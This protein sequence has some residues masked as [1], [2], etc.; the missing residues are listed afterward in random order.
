M[1]DAW[2]LRPRQLAELSVLPA[3]GH[4]QDFTLSL[5]GVSLQTGSRQ[6][7]RIL[8]QVPVAIR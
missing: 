5:F 7:P 8:A 1:I 6:G 3:K 2:V 4:N